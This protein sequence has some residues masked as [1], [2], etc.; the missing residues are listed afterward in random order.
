ME[1][2]ANYS[3]AQLEREGAPGLIQAD[4][5]SRLKTIMNLPEDDSQ[6]SALQLRNYLAS[7]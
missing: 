2:K 1:F 3:I 5:L 7:D 6:K 4:F